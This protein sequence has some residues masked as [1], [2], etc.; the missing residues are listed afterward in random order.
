MVQ[1]SAWRLSAW[2][3]PVNRFCMSEYSIGVI[4]A[5]LSRWQSLFIGLGPVLNIISFDHCTALAVSI[6]VL[7]SSLDILAWVQILVAYSRARVARA[8]VP[9]LRESILPNYICVRLYPSFIS[10]PSGSH[11]VSPSRLCLWRPHTP[12]NKWSFYFEFGQCK[13]GCGEGRNPCLGRF[14][15]FPC[16]CHW[17]LLIGHGDLS[18]R[19]VRDLCLPRSEFRY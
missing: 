14:C 19:F 8:H 13:L 4:P 7:R 3:G 16:F 17:P 15:L 1:D 6:T 18:P 2:I 9:F 12:L 10:L 5:F 11:L